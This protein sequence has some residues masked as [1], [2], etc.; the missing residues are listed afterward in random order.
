MVIE[1]LFTW[2]EEHPRRRN[3]FSLGLHTEVSVRLL[4][5]LA[6]ITTFQQNY[7]NN[8]LMVTVNEMVDLYCRDHPLNGSPPFLSGLSLVVGSS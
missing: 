2:G 5:L 1:G 3:N 6:V 7:H 4:S 8:Q